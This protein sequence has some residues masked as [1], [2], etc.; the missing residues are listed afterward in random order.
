MKKAIHIAGFI[1]GVIVLYALAIAALAQNPPQ[2]VQSAPF[3]VPAVTI[4]KWNPPLPKVDGARDSTKIV[5][6]ALPDGI[7]V[8][9]SDWVCLD[10]IAY[11]HIQK[12]T[13]ADTSRY[14]LHSED[15]K[16]HCLKLVP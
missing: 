11:H 13:C 1:I 6:C 3:D 10:G 15:G 5:P 7:M 8:N 14:L 4:D 9:L 16:A 2:K 12:T